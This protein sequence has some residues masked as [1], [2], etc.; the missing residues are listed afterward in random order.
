MLA[1]AWPELQEA[2]VQQ[3][4]L[5]RQVASPLVLLEQALVQPSLVELPLERLLVQLAQ[6]ARALAQLELARALVSLALVQQVASPPELLVLES[7]ELVEPEVVQA[8][9]E[10]LDS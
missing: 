1:L 8:R 7:L 5:V 3:Q 6:Q 4:A 9:L 10:L 2:V